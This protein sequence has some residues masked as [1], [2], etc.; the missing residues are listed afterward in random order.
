MACFRRWIVAGI[1]LLGLFCLVQTCYADGIVLNRFRVSPSVS[2]SENYSDNIFLTSSDENG[3]FI[4]AISPEVSLD[5]ALAVRNIVNLTYKMNYLIHSRFQNFKKDTHNLSL[6]YGYRTRK[7]SKVSLGTDVDFDSIQPYSASDG[8]KDFRKNTFY[9]DALA[10]LS[11]ATESGLR[12]SHQSRRY[13]DSRYEIDEYDRSTV[14]LSAG[15]R[16]SPVTTVF[17]EYAYYYQENHVPSG[18]PSTDMNTNT[19]FLGTKWAATQKISGV[20]KAGYTSTDFKEVSDFSGVVADTVVTYRLSDFTRFELMVFRTLVKSTATA[21]ES[22]TYY[23]SEGGGFV[24]AYAGWY[25]LVI[26]AGLLYRRNDYSDGLDRKDRLSSSSLK[27]V[28]GYRGWLDCLISY[29]YRRNDS[30]VD[31][32]TYG[33]NRIA[34]MMKFSI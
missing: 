27:A 12:I 20:L 15:H 19:V 31:G 18:F 29:E 16:M 9:I 11:S 25:P 6:S 3:E 8:H 33:E 32:E 22:G 4:T 1:C 14:T 26:R 13:E 10:L 28:Y 34:F 17:L 5:F 7:G 2:V 21:R 23:I 30:N 24:A